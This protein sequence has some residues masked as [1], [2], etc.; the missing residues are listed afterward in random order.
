M[1]TKMNTT[2][3][4]PLAK[5]TQKTFCFRGIWAI[6]VPLLLIFLLVVLVL[7]L[8][9]KFIQG[10]VYRK[11]NRIDGKVVIVTGC[12]TGIGKE[13]VLELARRGAKIYMACRDPAR[14]EAARIEI[15]DRTQNQQLFN[16]SLDL[17]S[18]ESVRNFVAR[19][20]AEESRLDLLINNAGIMACPRSLTAD[21]YEQQFG[22]NHLGHFLLTNLLLDLLKQSS[23]SRIV[24]VSSVAHIFGRINR[25][26]L[27]S[28]RKYSKF[29]GAYSQ[30]KLSNILFTKK[31]ST[32]LKDSG[33]TVN[34][35]HP[36]LVRTELNRHF[37]G[38]NWTRNTLKVLSLYLFKTPRAG[39]Q[40]SLRL[41]LDPSLE[42]STGGYYSDCMRFPVVPWASDMDTANWLWT[43]SE[44]LVGLPPIEAPPPPK[45][46]NGQNGVNG[47][48][49]ANGD[50]V[51][52]VVVDRPSS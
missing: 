13:T 50:T 44:K 51:E 19:F 11:K 39:A 25:D 18:L 23:P 33:V 34:C 42:G 27:M 40:T 30:S 46:Q 28:E 1:N 45:T 38:P 48:R 4:K 10:P 9:R 6:I 47:T 15:I 20:K 32:L 22:V 5:A 3:N 52:T 49:S 2:I 35:C 17:G 24:V 12:N 29:F 31:L 7:W 36:G 26:D 14:C 16:R 43:E 41:A 8:I 21:G 37:S